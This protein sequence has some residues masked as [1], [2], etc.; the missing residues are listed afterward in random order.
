MNANQNNIDDDLL[1]RYLLGEADDADRKELEDWIAAS[2]ANRKHFDHFKAIWEESLQFASSRNV[3]ENEAWERLVSRA[4]AEEE[5]NQ[6]T[7]Q[8]GRTIP[9]FRSVWLRAAATLVLCTGVGAAIYTMTNYSAGMMVARSGNNVVADTLPDG[10]VV[11]LNKNSTL[12]YP[13]RFHGGKRK[14]SLTG[15]AFFTITPDKSKPFVI[16]ASNTTVTVVGT[17]FNVRTSAEQTEVIVETG[18]VQ[19]AKKEKSVQLAPHEKATVSMTKDEPEKEINT[20]ELYNYYRTRE[21][22]CNNTALRKLVA[23]LNESYGVHIAVPDIKTR[24]LPLTVTFKD[25]PLD[26]ILKVIKETLNL[27]IEHRGNDIF[28]APANKGGQ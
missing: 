5:H 10:S 26:H 3:N 1:A 2:A 9:F 28:L 18:I 25:E 12:S 22:V 19:V 15:E 20:D 7:P 17:T 13:S 11:V 8:K 6:Q 14:V 27:T 24:E 23:V 21:F 4:R 16:D